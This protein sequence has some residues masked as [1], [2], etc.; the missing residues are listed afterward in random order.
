MKRVKVNVNARPAE[1]DVYLETT[2]WPK[3][4]FMVPLVPRFI[5]L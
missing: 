3:Q 1:S 5:A 4:V 2:N